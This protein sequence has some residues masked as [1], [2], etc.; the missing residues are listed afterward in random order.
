MLLS[1]C[2]QGG[3]KC[4]TSYVLLAE[5]QVLVLSSS[6]CNGVT[7]GRRWW[8]GCEALKEALG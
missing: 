5:V 4:I 8:E 7:W 6:L 2:T 1:S 3:G